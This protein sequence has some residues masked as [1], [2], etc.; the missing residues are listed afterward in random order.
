MIFNSIV[1]F[2]YDYPLRISRIASFGYFEFIENEYEI[3]SNHVEIAINLLI[4]QFKHATNLQNLIYCYVSILQELENTI[5]QFGSIKSIDQAFGATL[6]ILGD[7]VGQEREG[8]DDLNYRNAIRLKILLNHS[9][10]QP[11]ILIIALK[12]L[13]NAKRVKY[14]EFFPACVYMDFNT[15]MIPQSNLQKAIESI[16]LAGVKIILKFSNV[17]DHK[18]LRFK[19]ELGISQLP[20]SAGFSEKA[21]GSLLYEGGKIFDLI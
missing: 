21:N 8:R 3:I 20:D 7:I 2:G 14:A 16:A 10:G 12:L 18:N 9:Y 11:E 13:V 4:E 6:N 15:Y 19:A 5:Q 17:D 1:I